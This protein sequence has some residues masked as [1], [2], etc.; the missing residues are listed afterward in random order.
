M[1]ENTPIKDLLKM[2]TDY[3]NPCMEAL[4]QTAY[5]R[6]WSDGAE[7]TREQIIDLIKK[8]NMPFKDTPEGET[9]S[10]PIVTIEKSLDNGWYIRFERDIKVHGMIFITDAELKELQFQLNKVLNKLK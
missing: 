5:N 3:D 9:H 10:Y 1:A 8:I 2:A 7:T 6:G 4:L